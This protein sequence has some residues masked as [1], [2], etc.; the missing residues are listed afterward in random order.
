MFMTLC[1]K[2]TGSGLF[3]T[4]IV[5]I[6]LRKGRYSEGGGDDVW[7]IHIVFFSALTL[8]VG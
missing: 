1:H 8:L 2:V 4:N 5:A 6:Y 7:N 3:L